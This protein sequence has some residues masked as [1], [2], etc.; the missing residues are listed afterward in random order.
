MRDSPDIL[1]ARFSHRTLLMMEVC[2]CSTPF[3]K[4]EDPEVNMSNTSS[5]GDAFAFRCSR[6]A[7][8]SG[9][10]FEMNASK[11]T[12]PRGALPMTRI[13]RMHANSKL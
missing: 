12:M 4:P 13:S 10:G 1:R 6:A 3:G 11:S 9:Y 7:S 5:S 2:V 8:I